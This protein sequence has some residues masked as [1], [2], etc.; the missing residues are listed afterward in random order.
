MKRKNY[1]PLH[2]KIDNWIRRGFETIL[3]ENEEVLDVVFRSTPTGSA[4]AGWSVIIGKTVLGKVYLHGINFP[5]TGKP[6]KPAMDQ[7]ISASRDVLDKKISQASLIVTPSQ[8]S[9][10]SLKGL[11]RG[12]LGKQ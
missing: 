9:E 11:S 1:V 3:E 7:A 4:P 10:A 12:I 5:H 6:T 8:A 2:V